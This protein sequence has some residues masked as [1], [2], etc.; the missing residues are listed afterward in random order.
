MFA[1]PGGGWSGDVHE[2]AVLSSS[3]G[4]ALDDPVVSGQEIVARG[5]VGQAPGV[6]Y[7][8][9]EPQGGWSGVVHEDLPSLT[10]SDGSPGDEFGSS[11]AASG[12]TI[13]VGAPVAKVGIAFPG[14]R[15]R[16]SEPAAGWAG[17]VHES[18]KLTGSDVTAVTYRVA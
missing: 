17:T 12:T 3:D 16:I 8:F 9:T 7:V 2:T 13:V 4:V 6:V 14:R 1:P 18:A 10:A 15:V 5:S 11:I